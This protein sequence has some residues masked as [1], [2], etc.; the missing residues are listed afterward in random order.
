[1]KERR[2]ATRKLSPSELI[3]ALNIAVSHETLLE[4]KIRVIMSFG[5][6]RWIPDSHLTKGNE[7]VIVEETF[8]DIRAALLEQVFGEFRPLIL[9]MRSA[10]YDEDRH[11]IRTLL[12]E[13]EHQMFHE[14]T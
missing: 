11:R 6:D 12:A 4:S 7:N 14:N 3:P 1:M 9:E 5:C 10:L 2:F 8:N 13:L